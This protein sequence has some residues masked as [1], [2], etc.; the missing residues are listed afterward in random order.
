M[1]QVSLIK[2]STLSALL[3]MS[4]LMLAGE[5]INETLNTTAKGEV[6][7]EV[8]NGKVTIKTWDKNEVQVKGEL[9]DKA[10]G[11]IFELDGDRVTFEVEMPKRN[12]SGWGNNW[13]EN[14]STLEIWMPTTNRVR[15]EGV[16]TDIDIENVTGGSKV[17]TV[18][19]DIS[20][21]KLSHRVSLETVNGKINADSLSGD[22]TLNTVN[23][24]VRDKNSSGELHIETVNGDIDSK[25]DATKLTLNNVNG[26]L[27]IETHKSSDTDVS[28][29]N[30]DLELTITLIEDSRLVYSSVGGDADI[31]F[32]GD[33][34]A[35]FD[36]ETHAGG[37]IDNYLTSERARKD[38]YGP[39]EKLRFK[40][41]KGSADVEIDTVSGDVSLKK[42]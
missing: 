34:S 36:I 5:K 10:E 9:D 27:T 19:G 2:I 28:T 26:D 23:G 7:L 12:W 22:I 21:E 42:K 18:N 31:F 33:I 25:T 38:K 24:K 37:D 17:N 1:K 20:A 14:G 41:G 4:P 16:N 8:M 30:G 3:M 40:M 29:V 32:K 13:S 6:F 35:D 15:F 39:G 11:F